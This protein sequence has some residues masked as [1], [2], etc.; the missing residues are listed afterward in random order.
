MATVT[1]TITETERIA[2]ILLANQSATFMHPEVIAWIKAL[3]TDLDETRTIDD[4][5]SSAEWGMPRDGLASMAFD[6]MISPAIDSARMTRGQRAR[7]TLENSAAYSLALELTYHRRGQ[8]LT[9]IEG[10]ILLE[11]PCQVDT[12]LGAMIVL[13][14][15][16]MLDA[17]AVE[18]R[19]DAR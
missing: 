10:N 3:T 17:A 19:H 1:R 9:T 7:R 12:S 13:Y 14:H 5:T 18:R 6:G 15:Q 2:V 4:F 11:S 16:N 8:S